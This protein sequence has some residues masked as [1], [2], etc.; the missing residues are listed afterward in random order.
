MRVG[1]GL[2]ARVAQTFGS[3]PFCSDGSWPVC[4]DGSGLL[5]PPLNRREVLR[6]R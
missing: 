2:A 4:S 5:L 6:R 3:W 1:Y